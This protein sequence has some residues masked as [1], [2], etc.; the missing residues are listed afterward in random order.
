MAW[1]YRNTIEMK[2]INCKYI[3]YLDGRV[4]L[5]K[6][7]DIKSTIVGVYVERYPRPN[8]HWC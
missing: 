8:M 4:V 3:H 7:N 2:W 1:G 6:T 5:Y